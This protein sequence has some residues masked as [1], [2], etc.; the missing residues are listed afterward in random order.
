MLSEGMGVD[1]LD[2]GPSSI[3]KN[4]E[5]CGSLMRKSA[6]CDLERLLHIVKIKEDKAVAC[7]ERMEGEDA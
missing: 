5:C 3:S 7:L 2:N 4:V 6:A 1:A